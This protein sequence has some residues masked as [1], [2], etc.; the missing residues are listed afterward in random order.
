MTATVAKKQGWIRRL[1][2]YMKP[3]KKNAYV[4]FGVAIG[5]QLIQSLLPVVQKIV[6]D[7]VIT[8][9]S[10][11]GVHIPG[12]PL[13]PWLALMI[14]MGVFTFVFAYFRR[15]RGGRIALDVQ[16]DL[17]TAVFRQ[18]QHLD[19]ASQDELQTGQLVSRASSDVALL[20]GFLQF[21]PIGVANILLFIV[22]F[23]AMLWLSPLL[24]LVMLAVAPLLLVTAMRLRTSVFPASWDAQQKAGDVANVVEEDVTGVRVVKGFGQEQRELERLTGRSREMF[25]SR[26]RLVNIQAR[27]QPAMQTI[28]AFGQVA[29]LALGGWLALNGRITL[30]TFLAFSTYM[31]LIT[32]PIRQLAAILTVGQLARAGAE[33]I[34]DLLDST[35]VVQNA[36]DAIDLEIPR[37]EVRFEHVTFGYTSTDPVLR[38]FDLT[39]ASG[40]TV[41]LVGSSGS[42]KS[43]VALMLPRFYDVHSGRITIDGVDVR[44]VRLDSLRRNIGVVFE[45]SFLFSDTITANIGFGRPDA[46]REEVETAARAAEAHEFILRLPNGY[47]TVVGEQGLTLSGGQR[48]R[49]A[50]ARALLS[51]PKILLLDDAT[52]SV[53]SRVEEEIHATLKQIASTRTTILIAHRRSSLSLADRIVV[54]DEGAVLDAGTHEELWERCRLY[55]ML[56]SGPGGDAEGLDAG[57]EEPDDEQVDGLTPAAWRG[58]DREEIRRAQIAERARTASP[59]AAV[60]VAGGG[61]GGGGMG[62]SGGWGGAL[63]PTPELLA[64]VDALGPATADPHIDVAAESRPAPDFKFL[65]FIRRY[66]GWLLT[67]MLLVA[68]DAVCTLA[69]PLLVRHGID[70]GVAHT[71]HVPRAIWAA[72]I[73]FFIVTLID[74][75]LMWAE[76]RVMGR[77]SERMLHGLRVKV[78]AHLQRLGVE[79]YEQEMAGR[80]MT[81]M[82]TDID[83]LSQL[84][85]N[86]L[87]NALVNLVTFLGVGIA[88]G[89]MDPKLGLI[90]ASILPP[91]VVAT[92]WFRSASTR[93]YGIARD[94]IA[95]VNANLQ[96]GLSGVRVSQAFVR[97]D[98]NQEVFTEIASGYRDARVHA[99]RLVAIYFPLVDFLS[100]IATCVV[101]GAGSVLVAHQSLSV[102]ELI[103]F[104][105]YLNLFFAPIQQLSQVFDSYQQARVAIE[106]ITELLATPTTVPAP[107]QPVVP[108]RI[109]G[110]VTLEDVHF[111]YSTA[112]DEA[113][114]GVN[115]HV[116]A[117]ETVALVGET[118]A[119]KSTVVKLVARFYDSTAGAVRVD[120]VPVRDYDPVA[121]HQQLG[122]VPQEAFLFSGTIRDNIAYGRKDASDAEVE[123]AAREVGAHDFIA[124][125]PG[126]YLQWVSERGRSLSSGQRQL[127]ALAR[128]HLVDPAILLLDEATSN[129]DLQTEA[130]VQ[131][132][133]G[134]AAHGR[135]TVLIAHRLQTA[136]LADRIVVID[137]GRVVEDGTHEHLLARGAHYAR[138]WQSA[139][140]EPAAAAS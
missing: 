97:E 137:N 2:G 140:G 100:D 39:V 31:L 77:V 55:R 109:R 57:E 56:L 65:R 90:T 42:G 115:L 4:A 113:L 41:A 72:A 105:L 84:L 126:G 73:V 70:S 96:E 85:Q 25:A 32:P 133:M 1:V 74:W 71:P 14:A 29:V 129:L 102:G 103:A 67:G 34:Y 116:A 62:A 15:F 45:D 30:G 130:K 6:V 28:P 50:L 53:D 18:L 135:T 101:L 21:L 66:R 119:G 80:I 20:Q 76:A 139:E 108:G 138:M 17:R 106:R 132:A 26:V 120:G 79:Y 5:G 8:P 107:A 48:Q 127:I 128:A 89:I 118:G 35:P 13:A 10:R 88:L 60:R 122:V 87:V 81:R 75:W 92:I 49:V 37:A 63:A 19:F 104:L 99:Q 68:L 134:V 47:D 38:D 44:D 54:M 111:K 114:R 52:S 61:G 23:G 36:P 7:D 59:T 27:L 46:T 91:L 22:S 33:R 43:T 86:G 40:E 121:F 16:H 9:H 58:L 69:G 98:R 11:N 82:T 95:A 51:D 110:E 125:L 117:G 3:H 93:A 24:S 124:T 131:R 12:K 123:A 78:F 112:I 94:R 64:Q 83:A 136:R